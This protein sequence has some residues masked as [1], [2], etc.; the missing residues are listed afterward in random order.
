MP[1]GRPRKRSFARSTGQHSNRFGTRAAEPNPVPAEPNKA[2]APDQQHYDSFTGYNAD[3]EWTEIEEAPRE[4]QGP[5][6]DGYDIY[7]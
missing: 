3:G 6:A 4:A 7:Y 1:A 2:E 5:A